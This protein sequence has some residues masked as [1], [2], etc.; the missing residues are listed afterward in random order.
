MGFGSRDS[1]FGFRVL[2]FEFR[3]PGDEF[4]VSDFGF[5][6]WV[7]GLGLGVSGFES[8]VLGFGFRVSGFGFPGL[9]PSRTCRYGTPLPSVLIQSA[10]SLESFCKEPA[11][12]AS[13]WIAS[14]SACRQFG[15]VRGSRPFYD[16]NLTVWE[17][18]G[19]RDPL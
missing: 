9:V 12:P 13:V 10:V 1:G 7:A 8:R 18:S 16:R 5:E 6:F 11:G 17:S 2:G 4:R 19:S 3:V 14:P 15:I